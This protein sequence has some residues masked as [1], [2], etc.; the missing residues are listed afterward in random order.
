MKICNKAVGKNAR[1]TGYCWLWS[2]GL[3][4]MTLQ[5]RVNLKLNVLVNLKLNVTLNLEREVKAEYKTD[6]DWI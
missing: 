4:Q 6:D 5:L 2:E 3:I 1:M